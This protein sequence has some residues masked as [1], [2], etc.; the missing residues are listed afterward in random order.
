MPNAGIRADRVGGLPTGTGLRIRVDRPSS[1]A[2]GTVPTGT[3]AHSTS[4]IDARTD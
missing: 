4:S 1:P 2:P 3:A